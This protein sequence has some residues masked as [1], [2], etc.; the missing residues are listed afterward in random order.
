MALIPS[1]QT[2]TY[3]DSKNQ[4]TQVLWWTIQDTGVSR[5]V[6]GSDAVN[7]V[8]SL[9]ALSNAALVSAHGF[10]EI[11]PTAVVSGSQSQY[12]EVEDKA[13]FTFQT[14]LGEIHRYQVPCPKVAIFQADGETVDF[15]NGL[16]KQFIADW[17]AVAFSGTNPTAN[18]TL[19][20]CS[21]GGIALTVSNGGIRK[22][23]AIQRKFNTFTRNPALTGQ[24]L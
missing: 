24:G 4:T 6:I 22:R 11:M 8:A 1:R 18:T 7:K 12:S 15:T 5:D 21:R 3:R 23:V 16:V 19:P 20:V 14:A 13:V 17:L 2:A 9:S 10:D